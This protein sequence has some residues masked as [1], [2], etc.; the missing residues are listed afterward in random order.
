MEEILASIRRIIEES[1]TTRPDDTP[2]V[3][4]NSDIPSRTAVPSPILPIDTAMRKPSCH[5][6]KASP[7]Q[8]PAAIV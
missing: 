7:S 6:A 5:H 8:P 4:V 2:P 3:P 1:D